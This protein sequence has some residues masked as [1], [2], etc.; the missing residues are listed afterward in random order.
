M[1]NPRC[2]WKEPGVISISKEKDDFALKSGE[3]KSF[4]QSFFGENNWDA[5]TG[6][7]LCFNIFYGSK[8]REI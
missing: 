5:Y 1:V 7:S 3:H 2:E 8:S 6:I 4:E